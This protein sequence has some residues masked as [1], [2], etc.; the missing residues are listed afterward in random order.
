MPHRMTKYQGSR[1][2]LQLELWGLRKRSTSKPHHL[3][4][5]ALNGL[6]DNMS[7]FAGD[8]LVPVP[9]QKLTPAQ[10]SDLGARVRTSGIVTLNGVIDQSSR[11]KH[12][13]PAR[14]H[15]LRSASQSFVTGRCC[16]GKTQ[17]RSWRRRSS[18]RTTFLMRSLRCRPGRRWK[19]QAGWTIIARG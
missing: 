1:F 14:L 12:Q 5:R 15:R 10:W 19:S 16:N 11:Q 3:N 18:I 2:V 8:L 4:R 6:L 7:M 13:L 9:V 17:L